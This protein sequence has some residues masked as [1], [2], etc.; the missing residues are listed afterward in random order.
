M[1]ETRRLDVNF[2]ASLQADEELSGTVMAQEIGSSH[3]TITS[4]EVNDEDVFIGHRTA[5]KN[6][7]VS[8]FIA[9]GIAGNQYT[10]RITVSTDEG[11]TLIAVRTF[12]VN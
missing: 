4:A 6:Q 1:G 5:I 3:L 9:G 12:K 11:Q 7:S 10:V 2:S 8:C